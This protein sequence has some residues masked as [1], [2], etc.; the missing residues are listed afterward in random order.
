MDSNEIRIIPRWV[1]GHRI[2]TCG[3][4]KLC[5]IPGHQYSGEEMDDEL[6]RG[7]SKSIDLPIDGT[8]KP[9]ISYCVSCFKKSFIEE[10]GTR[11]PDAGYL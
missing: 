8:V 7:G 5:W 9:P 10:D 3:F 6:A 4:I 1:L 11:K 2:E